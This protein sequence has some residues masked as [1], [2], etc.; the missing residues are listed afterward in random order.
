MYKLFNH[1]GRRLSNQKITSLWEHMLTK[2][3][4]ADTP[5][6]RGGTC[7]GDR[8]FVVVNGD[9]VLLDENEQ[10]SHESNPCLQ[11][12]CLVRHSIF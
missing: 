11:Y 4:Q 6:P 10:F 5:P 8:C 3:M 7:Q 9:G 1:K 12:T 2:T